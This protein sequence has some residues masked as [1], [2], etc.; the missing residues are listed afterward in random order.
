MK[1]NY[2]HNVKH[3]LSGGVLLKEKRSCYVLKFKM[4]LMLLK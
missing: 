1:N 2:Y 4:S 3:A